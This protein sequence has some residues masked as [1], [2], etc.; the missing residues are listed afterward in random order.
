M[1]W[2][3]FSVP[4]QILV[5]GT[6]K[7]KY[8]LVKGRSRYVHQIASDRVKICRRGKR[9][10]ERRPR[11]GSLR[12]GGSKSSGSRELQRLLM[13]MPGAGTK[14]FAMANN[15]T[16]GNYPQTTQRLLFYGLNCVLW[17]LRSK[18]LV[19]LHVYI[20]IQAQTVWDHFPFCAVVG[21]AG[22][23]AA[24]FKADLAGHVPDV[25]GAL[26]LQSMNSYGLIQL[27]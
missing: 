22:K 26:C 24:A 20:Q 15:S 27:S 8:I 12:A 16:C 7:S 19:S 18:Y 21:G 3:P 5:I 17:Q 1:K 14:F 23:A 13:D 11:L 10:A 9:A 4:P 6:D 25:R 2:M